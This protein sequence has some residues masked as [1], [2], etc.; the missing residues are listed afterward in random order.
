M[1]NLC[2]TKLDVVTGNKLSDTF[3]T[4]L[5]FKDIQNILKV[6][7]DGLVLKAFIHNEGERVTIVKE[8]YISLTFER[9]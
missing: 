9:C 7:Q 4:Q 5:E 3:R 6:C 1:C 8:G 2:I